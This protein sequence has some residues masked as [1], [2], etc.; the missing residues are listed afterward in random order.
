MIYRDV[1]TLKLAFSWVSDFILSNGIT[2]IPDWWAFIVETCGVLSW[3]VMFLFAIAM[4]VG[5]S[6]QMSSFYFL[7]EQITGKKLGNPYKPAFLFFLLWCSLYVISVT[8]TIAGVYF[9]K[10]GYVYAALAIIGGIIGLSLIVFIAFSVVQEP[11]KKSPSIPRQP[12][13]NPAQPYYA[14][15]YSSLEHPQ[16][17]EAIQTRNQPQ[18]GASPQQFPLKIEQNRGSLSTK[19]DP[20][21]DEAISILGLERSFTKTQLKKKYHALAKQFHSD[22]GGT[23]G[24]YL[25]IKAC[26][27]YLIPYAK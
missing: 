20:I 24:L 14:P 27:E 25:K 12:M 9:L 11:E 19:A 18:H 2:K 26:Y 10:Y 16:N 8:V 5:Y 21:F 1:Q 4:F 17:Y 13:Q 7:Y 6:R 23:N 22:K 15:A 3:I